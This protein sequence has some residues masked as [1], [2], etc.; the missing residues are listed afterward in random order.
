M[1][2][3]LENFGFFLDIIV[4]DPSQIETSCFP[5]LYI[6]VRFNA[7]AVKKAAWS[8]LTLLFTVF[9]AIMRVIRL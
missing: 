5:L 3:A 4:S 8:V 2:G 7:I 9:V 6:M 1:G